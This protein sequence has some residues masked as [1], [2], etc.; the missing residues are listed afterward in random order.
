MTFATRV[1]L[2]TVLVLLA[3]VMALALAADRWLRHE[4]EDRFAEELARQTRLVAA[5]LPRDTLDLNRAAHDLGKLVGR[6]VT[7]ISLDGRVLGDSDFDDAS[8]ALL[9]NHRNRPEV[10]AALGGDVGVA[11]R[12]SAST[13][14]EELKVAIVAWPGIVRLSA[15][16][17]Q[18]DS[19]VGGAQQTVLLAAL[20]AVALGAVLAGIAG[21]TVTGPIRDLA[22]EARG[23]AAG[24]PPAYPARGTPEIRELVRA[25][26]SMHDELS[27]R[28]A[29]LRRER[30]E[31]TTMI[32]SMAE[33]VIATDEDGTVVITNDA[34]RR[35]L[36]YGPTD[37]LPNVRELFHQH[38][39]QA[40]VGRVLAEEGV[41]A[42]ETTIHGRTILVTGRPLPNG[43]AVLGLNDVTEF[44]R[45]EIV[46]RDFVANVSHE[47]KTPLTSV[48]GYLETFLLSDEDDATRRQF[49]EVALL[50]GRR[51]QRLVDDLL[52]LSRLEAGVW[53]PAP[54]EVS[55]SEVSA[56]VWAPFVERAR[57]SEITFEARTDG[58]PTLTADPDAVRQILSN[59]FGNAVRHTPSGGRILFEARRTEGGVELV[60]RDTGVGIP[61]EHLSR[62][63]ERFYRVDPGRSRAEGGTGLGLAIV[64]HLAEGH[65]GRVEADS[66]IGVG[67]TVRVV[68]PTPPVTKS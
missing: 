38:D 37:T 6:R 26:R 35:A 25:L 18:V 24:I 48:L 55:T 54:K 32:D 58:A 14:R 50:N 16:L 19:V 53:K 60:V 31:T 27:E 56:E 10:L 44:R 13:G 49:V 5:A 1:F 7:L 29:D 66:T 39:A 59:L 20:A 36:G 62:V 4:L 41:V 9:E 33:G 65:G 3:T 12:L 45:L 23:L 40:I 28:M 34:A 63:F 43:G 68:L 11:S 17:Q 15:T 22:R 42:H 8:L 30:E 47:L 2:G 51:M 52:D 46:R 67:T 61:G 21:R 64:K 57:E